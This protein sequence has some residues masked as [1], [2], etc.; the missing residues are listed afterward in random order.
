MSGVYNRLKVVSWNTCKLRLAA[1]R[2][3]ISSYH[4]FVERPPV[5]NQC[6]ISI[7]LVVFCTV[8]WFV[9]IFFF[10]SL[11]PTTVLY[12]SVWAVYCMVQWSVMIFLFI[13][14]SQPVLYIDLLECFF[15]MVQWSIMIFFYL[16]FLF[17]FS[18]LYNRLFWGFLCSTDHNDIVFLSCVL[19]H[20]I[21]LCLVQSSGLFLVS[22]LC[23]ISVCLGCFLYRHVVYNNI[24]AYFVFPSSVLHHLLRVCFCMVQWSVIIILSISCAHPVCFFTVE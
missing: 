15:F 9:M 24:I 20:P 2:S 7:C 14:C 22:I 17:P 8:Q 1:V 21:G 12:Q 10:Y 19:H 3:T 11:F 18:V 23:S 5:P 4:R 16:F 6:Y 13:P